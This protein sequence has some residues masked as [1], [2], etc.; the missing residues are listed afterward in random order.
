MKLLTF[1]KL[2]SKGLL[3]KDEW[4]RYY[5]AEKLFNVIYPKIKIS[6]FGNIYYE[7]MEFQTYYRDFVGDNFHSYDRKFTLMNLLKIVTHLSGNYAE[8][9]VFQGATAYLIANAMQNNEKL[10]LYDTFEGLSEPSQEDGIYWSKGDLSAGID[11]VKTRLKQFKTIEYKQGLIPIRFKENEETRFK[12][13]HVDVDLYQPTKDSIEFFYDRL[14]KGGLLICD[15]YGFKSCPGAK[16]AFDE[17]MQTKSENIIFLPTGQ[18]FI[19][20]E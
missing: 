18:A 19:I 4:S 1:I 11:F 14:V 10:F 17:V 3:L 5:L 12:F 2:L 15:D 8:C 9:G 13:V 7:D 20:K 6:E 16:K